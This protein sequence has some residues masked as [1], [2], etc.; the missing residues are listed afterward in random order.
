MSYEGGDHAGFGTDGS[1]INF[2]D[3]MTAIL[4]QTKF[5]LTLDGDTTPGVVQKRSSPKPDGIRL[6]EEEVSRK[7]LGIIDDPGS[8][9]RDLDQSDKPVV[10]AKY[11]A[12]PFIGSAF[13]SCAAV[14]ADSTDGGASGNGGGDSENGGDGKKKG[15]D[16]PPPLE[17]NETNE[18]DDATESSET[19]AENVIVPAATKKSSSRPPNRRSERPGGRISSRPAAGGEDGSGGE[20][21][22]DDED[23]KDFDAKLAEYAAERGIK[24]VE[25]TGYETKLAKFTKE[26]FEK[27]RNNVANVLQVLF[28][29]ASYINYFLKG[30]LEARQLYVEAGRETENYGSEVT[31]LQL[32][33]KQERRAKWV[34][35]E[36]VDGAF[37]QLNKLTFP[38]L[39]EEEVNEIKALRDGIINSRYSP[40]MEKLVM[41]QCSKLITTYRYKVEAFMHTYRSRSF[42]PESVASLL[43][44]KNIKDLFYREDG[45]LRTVIDFG[46]GDGETLILMAEK[47]RKLAEI[48]EW[49]KMVLTHQESGNFD[50]ASKEIV[51]MATL[52]ITDLADVEGGDYDQV[53]TAPSVDVQIKSNFIGIDQASS[54]IDRLTEN[55]NLGGRKADI[56]AP[57]SDFRSDTR[58]QPGS[59]DICITNLTFDRAHNRDALMENMARATKPGGKILIGL[60]STFS[61][62]SDGLS[63]KAG[64]ALKYNEN[65][66]WNVKDRIGLLDKKVI[67][68]AEKFGLMPVAVGRHPCKVIST[69][70][71]TSGPGSGPQIYELMVV[72]F[73]KPDPAKERKPAGE[74]DND[75]NQVG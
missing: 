12:G 54:F 71:K 35:R 5:D 23:S 25:P 15:N 38:A 19:G 6:R 9:S 27:R 26:K 68:L 10:R 39:A 7:I 29:D 44:F 1:T 45:T 64:L 20:F 34:L 59:A 17:S 4:S 41:K 75:Y 32:S 36:A 62:G 63:A 53:A 74:E 2:D 24:F 14:P 33:R 50:L 28:N 61:S 56:C 37:K 66:D 48:K 57:W 67:P 46:C 65:N 73:E 70:C 55:K 52:M 8:S 3:F 21:S 60:K 18:K 11:V 58:I 42:T 49:L 51:D 47:V 43:G 40:E 69:D 13:S 16:L 30:L 31:V 22:E 72:V